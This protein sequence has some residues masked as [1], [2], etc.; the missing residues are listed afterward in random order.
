MQFQSAASQTAQAAFKMLK[1][2]QGLMVQRLDEL[3]PLTKNSRFQSVDWLRAQGKFGGGNRFVS[4]DEQLFNRASVNVS[5][6]QYEQDPSKKLA[7]A[8]ALSTIIH[9]QNPN[10]PSLHLHVSWTEMKAGT[11]Y[12]RIMADLNPSLPLAADTKKFVSALQEV[13]G[14][15][16]PLGESEG[17]AYFFIPSLGRHRGVAHFYLEEYSSSHRA[18]DFNLAQNFG[19]KI[20]ETYADLVKNALVTSSS[21]TQADLQKQLEYHSLYFLQ[22]LT[23]DRGTISGLLVHDENDTGI[24]GSLPAYVDPNRLHSWAE[25][26]PPLQEELLNNIIATLA[27]G[28]KSL[29][30]DTVKTKIAFVIRDFYQRNPSGI[31]LL[32]RGSSVPPTLENHRA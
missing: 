23:L 26:L 15:L 3:P 17:Q 1:Q 18:D 6:V 14:S 16:Y 13:T 9:P 8:S 22:V 32:A 30:D 31:D 5:Q 21:V 7:S 24:L 11:S 29:V 12:W 19:I 4:F 28:E 10:A 25:K 20:I 2:L 27:P